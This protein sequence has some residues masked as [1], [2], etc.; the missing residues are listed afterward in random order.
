M[1]LIL[2]SIWVGDQKIL[3]PLL[4]GHLIG[5]LLFCFSGAGIS[6]SGALFSYQAN[7]Q[8]AGRWSVEILTKKNRLILCP[9]EELKVQKRGVLKK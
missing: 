8:S 7:W 9:L 6:I 4:R 1:L 5:I 3:L 2:P